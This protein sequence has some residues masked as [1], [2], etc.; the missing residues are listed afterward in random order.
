MLA[1]TSLGHEARDHAGFQGDFND[2]MARL[3]VWQ[4]SGVVWNS[5]ALIWPEF[6]SSENP[7]HL[8]VTKITASERLVAVPESQED[9]QLSNASGAAFITISAYVTLVVK[10][11]KLG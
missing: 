8:G 1:Y 3:E 9:K 5:N 7:G 6:L 11:H 4:N 10:I 2:V